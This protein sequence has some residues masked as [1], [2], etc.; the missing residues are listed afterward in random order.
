MI[1]C[2]L[3][4]KKYSVDFVSGRALPEMDPT[5][6]MYGRLVIATGYLSGLDPQY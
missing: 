6:K 4:E 1:T 3:G 2:T 5:S